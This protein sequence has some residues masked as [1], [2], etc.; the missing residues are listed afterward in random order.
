[1]EVRTLLIEEKLKQRF[2][3]LVNLVEGYSITKIISIVPDT[4]GISCKK[5]HASKKLTHISL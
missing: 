4:Q 1:M 3:R 5:S 2:E